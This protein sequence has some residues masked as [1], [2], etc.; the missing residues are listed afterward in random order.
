MKRSHCRTIICKKEYF[1]F[2][3]IVFFS[4][5]LFAQPTITSFSPASGPVGTSVTI[6]GTNFTTTPA[7]NIVFFG[8]VRATVNTA[9][10]NSL[11]VTVPVGATYQPITVTVSSLT[12]YSNKQFIVT[13]PGA[14][15]Q[16][17]SQSFAEETHVDSVDSNTETTKYA[18][19]DINND[20]KI[21]VIAVDRLNNKMSVYRNTTTGGQ[22]SFASKVDFT[23]AQSPRSAAVAD[24]DGDG[25]LDVIVTNLNTNTV[26]IF[27]NTSSGS[28]IALA[29]RV[30]FATSTQP[31]GIS[32]TDL[33]KDGRP[34]LVINTINLEGYISVLKNTTS[35]GTISF[36]AK[37][38]LQSNGGSIE[39]ISTGDLDGDGKTDIAIPNYSLYTVSIFR[40]TSPIG[41]ISFSPKVD[42]STGQYPDQLEIADLNNDGKP[43]L[44]V[45]YYLSN[46]ISIFR[47][48]S[49]SGSISFAASADYPTGNSTSGIAI[50]DLDG[51]GKPDVGVCG[52]FDSVSLFKNTST[53][54]GAISF[55]S[56]SKFATGLD[57]PIF[58]GDF[59]NDGK[60]DI[61]LHG[62]LFRVVIWKNRTTEPQII[63][64]TPA[65]GGPGTIVTI[66]GFNFS[67]VSSVSFGGIPASSFS[68]VNSTTISAVVDTGA[69]GDVVVGGS[70]GTSTVP[71]FVYTPRPKIVSFNPT[72]AALGTTVT[73][74][75]KNFSG[76]SAVTFGG[77][78]A[79]SFALVNPDTITAVVGYGS[80]GSV[81]VTTTYGSDSLAGFIYVTP[82]I[83]V[84]TS[85]VPS[86]GPVGASITISGYDFNPDTA[87][88]YVYFGPAKSK[89]VSATANTIVVLVP[90]GAAYGN[91]SVT[92]N[93]L[94][95]FSPRSFIP[96]FSGG[97]DISLGSFSEVSTYQ[98]YASPEGVCI[99]DFDLDGKNDLGVTSSGYAG[100]EIMRNTSNTVNIS[101]DPLLGFPGVY[102]SKMIVSADMDGDG[103]K[104]V[105]TGG[106]YSNVLSVYRNVSHP[107]NINF[108]DRLDYNISTA[109]PVNEIATGDI[110]GDGKSDLILAGYNHVSVVGNLSYPGKILLGPMS[111]IYLADFL[112][113]VKLGDVDGDGKLDILLVSGST[114][115]VFI[116]RNT[117]SNG[118]F[119]FDPPVTLSDL[120]P[121][122]TVSNSNDLCVND[123]D[124][125]GKPEI[126]VTH[127]DPSYS[128]SIL[129][130]NSIPG[131]L[132]FQLE[133]N[134]SIAP[135]APFTL[136]VEDL[137][138]DGKPD[139]VFNSDGMGRYISTI[140][141]NSS[142]DSLDFA[143]NILFYF[144]GG[145]NP[146]SFCT[147]DIN[148]DG[149]PEIITASG[150]FTSPGYVYIFKNQTSGPHIT[151]FTPKNGLADSIITIRGSN[152]S[153]ATSV[154]FGDSAAK[155][156]TVVSPTV[157]TA[158]LGHGMSG[159]VSVST[160]QGTTSSTGFYYGLAPAI[161][162]F[163]PTSGTTNA[164]IT[165]K[166]TNFTWVSDVKFG[167][168]SANS[169]TILSDTEIVAL[170]G[171]GASGNV[172]VFGSGDS[173]S[174]PGF[175]Y[176]PPPI[177]DSFTPDVGTTGTVIT[178]SGSNF[179]DV[180]NVSIGGTPADSFKV[181]SSSIITAIVGGGS[182]GNVSVTTALGGTAIFGYFHY[183]FRPVISS[184]SPDSAGPMEVIMIT[185]QNFDNV[186]AVSFGGAPAFS[187]T[188][189]DPTIIMATVG[190]GNSGDITVTTPGGTATSSG[191]TFVSKPLITSIAPAAA[192]T[193][194][195]VTINGINFTGTTSVSFGGVN[196]TSFEIN[197]DTSI[198]AIVGP[199]S[200]GNVS[201]TT[202]SG[203]AT[204]AGFTFIPPPTISS[205]SPTTA[206]TGATVTITGTNF[207]GVTS[208]S[209]GGAAASSF[210]V[211]DLTTITAIV[212]NGG[213]G[214]ITVVTIGGIATQPGFI[215]N[216]VTA[217][218]NIN[219]NSN[220][221]KV[222]PNPAKDYLV[223][224]HPVTNKSATI[225]WIDISGRIIKTISVKRN[226]T[227]TNVNTET[228]DQGV[229]K[230]VWTDGKNSLT[231]TV[232]ILK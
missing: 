202:P 213:S 67:G 95:G 144:D 31:S 168:V 60:P 88:N 20:G 157:I 187:F 218:G 82:K 98:T 181:V 134:L 227:K 43:E 143:Q 179:T 27:K 99:A 231:E 30:D 232:M 61:S 204:L 184:F 153:G 17:T 65:F 15:P 172:S 112:K 47:N 24:I 170:V 150:I 137:D 139:L 209:F 225:R 14:A 158:V 177:I 16:F 166:G 210:T 176:F 223:V 124:G 39:N 51:D 9:T 125:D 220:D 23:T 13:F 77:V 189:N 221:L 142:Q 10:S 49:T 132:S 38:D 113:S 79:I 208:V 164:N 91:V 163:N 104:D 71:G 145:L 102:A 94:T 151:S 214:N 229:Y 69:T 107:G 182:S 103:L 185:G 188:V 2:S 116:L 219:G 8:A 140:K 100:F 121:N 111:T 35:G 115:S 165:I 18:I 72:S 117:S 57:G 171:Y 85:V 92:S 62:G 108:T 119:S 122:F 75:G 186:S 110:D 178:I 207:T 215:Y 217:I 90:P 34:D 222:Y 174:L 135:A 120:V 46:S 148:N 37:I 87:L 25:K 86:S 106:V 195:S 203:T 19:G 154:F 130:N 26:S 159:N 93:S 22:V 11:T 190:N 7:N 205:F 48:T 169:F 199:G 141:N 28:T 152:F 80:S 198:T 59:D 211:V 6:S 156:F 146:A 133:K 45:S 70:S 74:S 160:P 58:T 96:T 64:F 3:C 126:A 193:G 201:I 196:A 4:I 101:F 228:L 131:N 173:T 230:I 155:S 63:S 97:G 175:I 44:A 105:I 216:V 206:G 118:I 50:N 192:A 183:F 127:I 128:I 162:S 12:A 149:R 52:I 123:L 83:P 212:G 42:I 53:G 138:G 33:D 36:A 32:V 56:I 147:A 84:I 21:D 109:S 136:G 78:P 41:S 161:S 81:A 226:E 76:T 194:G 224:E 29:S 129:K 191:F 66:K 114:D 68:V 5:D 167:G 73:I 180:T 89:P 40:N 197:A 55:A 54:G 1:L 200:S